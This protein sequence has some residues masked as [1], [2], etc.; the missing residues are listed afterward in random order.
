MF[1]K[2]TLRRT[3]LM[4]ALGLM[5]AGC[6]AP[7][8]NSNAATQTH[9]VSD[10][11]ASLNA[12]N[13]RFNEISAQHNVDG[14]ISLYTPEAL[15]IAPGERPTTG[16]EEPRKTFG[17]VANNKGFLSHTV[18][19]LHISD[20]GTQAVMIGEAVIKVEAA[21]VDATG[22]YLFVLKRQGDNTWKIVTDMFHQH[23]K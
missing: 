10:T 18:D 2:S 17:F 8:S 21:G 11:K 5:A 7:S 6:S 15:W 20:D 23:T 14:L 22:T 3:L 19:H 4:G 9:D 12:F 13:D 1:S 16:E